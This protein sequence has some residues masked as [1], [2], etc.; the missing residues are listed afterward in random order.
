MKRGLRD[1][2]AKERMRTIWKV[3][4]RYGFGDIEF[5][6]ECL[7]KNYVAVG[8]NYEYDLGKIDSRED[9]KKLQKRGRPAKYRGKNG[10]LIADTGTLWRFVKEMKIG[11]WVI[12][13]DYVNGLYHVGKVASDYYFQRQSANLKGCEFPNRR[14]VTWLAHLTKKDVKSIWGK[15]S[16]GGKMTVSRIKGNPASI[17]DV[18]LVKA[19]RKPKETMNADWKP[20]TEWGKA[21]EARAMAWLKSLGENPVDVS[22]ECK[23]WDIECGEIKYEVK[24]R[25]NARNRIRFT[26]NEFRMAKK[27]HSKYFLLIFTAP[28]EKELKKAIPKR[29]PAPAYT[30]GWKAKATWEYFMEEE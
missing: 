8:F 16:V 13:P 17:N 14:K 11:D 2:F 5:A 4:V 21:A 6:G 23:G 12:M 10:T 28:N 29:I 26:E 7:N 19:K 27:H 22:S 25:H 9:L 15:P 30:Y 1:S 24:G 18:I 3:Y 20:D